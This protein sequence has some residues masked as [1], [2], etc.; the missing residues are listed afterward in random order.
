MN[1]LSIYDLSGEELTI[2][3][4]LVAKNLAEGLTIDQQI[5]LGRFIQAITEDVFLL[6]A[7]LLLEQKR[8]NATTNQEE[9]IT[10]EET[11]E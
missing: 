4:A 9:D 6:N 8:S 7:K 11:S 1:K 2:L 10:E 5:L 3:A